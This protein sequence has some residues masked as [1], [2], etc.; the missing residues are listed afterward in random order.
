MFQGCAT[1]RLS[2]CV[3][4]RGRTA[5][6]H[7]GRLL[8][9]F[10]RC[11][12]SLSDALGASDGLPPVEVVV[13]HWPLAGESPVGEWLSRVLGS[14]AELH[15]VEPDAPYN[16]GRGRNEAAQAARGDG[17]FFLDADMLV[18]PALLPVGVRHLRAGKVFFPR[19]RRYTSAAED[20]AVVEHGTGNVFIT[21]A[22]FAACGGWQEPPLWGEEDTAFWRQWVSKKLPTGEPLMVR[23]D[24]PGFVHQW[25]PLAPDHKSYCTAKGGTR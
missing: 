8:R 9:L 7:D 6:P 17:L 10:P 12:E 4:L 2:V 11:M 1:K 25:H 24:V 23:D 14:R 5:L 15:V 18:P 19:Y 21:R 22:L 16:R 20:R 3:G 13:A